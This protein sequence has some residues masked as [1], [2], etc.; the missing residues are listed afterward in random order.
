LATRGKIFIS[1]RRD[2][3]PGDARGVCNR[4]ERKFGKANVFMD[5]DRLLAGQRFDRELDKALSQC[6]VLIAVIGPRWMDSLTEHARGGKR[7]FVHDEIAAALKRDIVV[8]PA[9]IGREG[10]MPSLPQRNDLPEEIRDL[11]LYQKHD[12]AHESFNRDADHLT[13]AIETVLHGGR[14][15][16]PWKAIAISGVM[17]LVLTV[18][19]LSYWMAMMPRIELE[20]RTLQ[21]SLGTDAAKG[22]A[23]SKMDADRAKAAA[24]EAAKRK[25]DEAARLAA[26]ECDRLA[27]SPVD[28]NRPSGVTGVD[29]AEIDATAAVS[30]CDNAMRLNLDIARFV[31][32]AGRAADAG[33]DYT[34]A[35]KLYR[36]ASEKGSAA[37]LNAI[38]T[39]Y[40]GGDGVPQDYA[41]AR[42]WYEKAAALSDRN[43]MFNLGVLYEEG[44]GGD[45]D[46]KQA[47]RWYQKAADSGD[48]E[49]KA[50][51]KRLK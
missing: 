19:L 21:P 45:K 7:D 40:N 25:T 37:A 15:A 2:D 31:F 32:Q 49:A 35:M 39:L 24:E 36:T 47:R 4:L 38:G 48:T 23:Q 18:V 43:A 30:S 3:V 51:L 50:A 1:Y 26:A 34:R 22:A 46:L 29:F 17:G 20:Q 41:E 5:V 27:A 12:I 42:K 28:A 11:V 8:I 6:D 10:H 14:R 13:A 16:R 33:K 44:N 9:L